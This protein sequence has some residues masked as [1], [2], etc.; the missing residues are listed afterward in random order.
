MQKEKILKALYRGNLIPAEKNVVPGR[1]FHKHQHQLVE[2]EKEIE[3]ILGEQEKERFHAYLTEQNNLFYSIGE[4]R[5]I[6]GFRM[7]AK[8]ILEIVE[9]DDG[10]LQSITD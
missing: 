3:T 6:D 1:E 2:L 7:G 10:Q 8:F 9:K 4:E 5:F